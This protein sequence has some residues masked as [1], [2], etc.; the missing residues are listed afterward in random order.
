MIYQAIYDSP[1][2]DISVQS[3][4][5]NVT[6]LYFVGQRYDGTMEEGSF[7][8]LESLPLWKTVKT[9]LMCYFK[10]KQPDP[11]MLPLAPKGTAFQKRVWQKLLA[12]LM[13]TLRPTAPLQQKL[14]KK[15]GNP[16]SPPKPWETRWTESHFHH[17]PCHR[18]MER[19]A[20]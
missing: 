14:Q 16:T 5:E 1:L 13:V 10:G 8:S 18:V 17:H 7:E 20:R 2:G 9:Y 6:A 12:I 4:G 15:M 19:M 11:G 3:D